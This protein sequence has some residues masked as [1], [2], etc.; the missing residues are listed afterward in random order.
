[1]RRS[2]THVQVVLLKYILDILRSKRIRQYT[3]K[4]DYPDVKHRGSAEGT[5]RAHSHLQKQYVSM[6]VVLYVLCSLYTQRGSRVPVVGAQCHCVGP[7]PL[8]LLLRPCCS[9]PWL[10]WSCRLPRTPSSALPHG[11]PLPLELGCFV[12]RQGLRMTPH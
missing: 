6:Y 1:M 11:C 2:C 5:M 12:D 4:V 7:A 10:F 8:I 9:F 3:S